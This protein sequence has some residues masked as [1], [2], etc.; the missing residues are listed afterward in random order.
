MSDT[1]PAPNSCPDHPVF[2]AGKEVRRRCS[3]SMSTV[4]RYVANGSFPQPLNIGPRRSAWLE[5]EVVAWQIEVIAGRTPKPG[6]YKPR[7]A[8]ANSV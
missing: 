7:S 3:I 5:S 4:T 6:A 2:L 1:A 8:A